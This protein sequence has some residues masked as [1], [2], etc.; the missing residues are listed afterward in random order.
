MGNL[1]E[2]INRFKLLFEY[3]TSMT[4]DENLEVIEEAS[5]SQLQDQFVDTGKITHEI[6]DKIIEATGGK[7]AYATWMIKRLEEESIKQEDIYKYKNYFDVF[8]RRK[9]DY[10]IKDINQIKQSDQ[11]GEFIKI[12][13]DI[14]EKE[15]EDPSKQKG[16]SKENK[17]DE[18]HI[19]QVEVH[20]QVTF[21][22]YKIPKGREDLYGMSCDLG[23]GT[24][25]CTATGK[26][27]KWFREYITD[28]PLYIFIGDDDKWQF[29][30]ETNSFMNKY[31]KPLMD[32]DYLRNVPSFLIDE[33]GVIY[34]TGKLEHAGAE[35]IIKAF[36]FLKQKE[37]R[38]MPLPL[39]AA[40]GDIT[41]ED[42]T[43]EGDVRFD[44]SYR[45]FKIMDGLHI[46]GNLTLERKK[47][48]NLDG[49]IPNNL[50]VDGNLH[51][52]N[53]IDLTKHFIL[54]H[55]IPKNIHKIEDRWGNT[56][57]RFKDG[58]TDIKSFLNN[59]IIRNDGALRREIITKHAQ[60]TSD[61]DYVIAGANYS[62]SEIYKLKTLFG[63]RIAIPELIKILE[64][65]FVKPELKG[66]DLREWI[67]H[68]GGHVGGDI[69]FKI[70]GRIG[71]NDV[72][73][74]KM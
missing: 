26:T 35:P 65:R 61:G 27:G 8:E 50:V 34:N 37:G 49:H 54:T 72:F 60:Q 32:L 70:E 45:T 42:L 43:I 40:L 48:E 62:E 3:D 46:K 38:T 5:I 44:Y 10:P 20:P 52:I 22:V 55:Y 71:N 2:S 1:S 53:L 9:R 28:G 13:V 57:W 12:S 41:K 30:F 39:K 59:Y 18:F 15:K 31:D 24:E 33:K 14:L 47:F 73:V 11:I 66:K 67:E 74:F 4:K 29:S 68:Y 25:W 6:F 36:D 58:S 17:Y 19:G 51:L 64:E 21:D 69:I 56:N 16:V 7:G 23:S 63:A